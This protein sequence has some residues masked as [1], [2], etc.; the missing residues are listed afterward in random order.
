MFSASGSASPSIWGRRE[1]DLAYPASGF[2]ECSSSKPRSGT[3]AAV[4][5]TSSL[6]PILRILLLMLVQA[7][8]GAS[9]STGAS[10]RTTSDY[11]YRLYQS[12]TLSPLK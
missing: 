5:A 11:Q 3:A 4:T 8:S 10:S 1:V 12:A 9:T 6:S 2:D 7:L